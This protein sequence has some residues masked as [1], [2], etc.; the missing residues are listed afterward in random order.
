MGKITTK[1]SPVDADIKK[2]PRSTINYN[3]FETY[4]NSVSPTDSNLNII[5]EEQ[6]TWA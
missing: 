6:M 5:S 2:N 1:K 4:S 3:I